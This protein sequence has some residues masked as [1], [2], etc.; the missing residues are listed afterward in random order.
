MAPKVQ[1]EKLKTKI[2]I[3]NNFVF[4]NAVPNLSLPKI[5]TRICT[6]SWTLLRSK[7][8]KIVQKGISSKVICIIQQKGNSW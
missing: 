1:I 4:L 2:V 3:H 6:K 7:E 5:K 8:T